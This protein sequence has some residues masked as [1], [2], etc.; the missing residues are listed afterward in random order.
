MNAAPAS[1]LRALVFAGA[2]ALA[3]GAS[4]L[5]VEAAPY[6]FASNQIT[7]LTVTFG[8]G[9]APTVSAATTS[10]TDVANFQ[11][12]PGSTFS[13]PNV[14]VG[15]A[16]AISMAT[17]GTG[18]FGSEDNWTPVGPGA[19]NGTRS[20]AAIG[21]G[22]AATGVS[23]RNVAEAYSTTSASGN[24]QAGNTANIQFTIR[25]ENQAVR[26]A[27]TNLIQLIANA[28]LGETA[29]AAIAN[30]LSV[31]GPGVNFNVPPGPPNL[32]ALNRTIGSGS[33][34]P[35]SVPF[36][37]ISPILTLGE[38]YILTLSSQAI[39]S[40]SPA[41]AVPEPA[42][43]ALLGLGLLGLAAMRRSFAA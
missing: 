17:A 7:G 27:G 37:I 14:A 12:F 42:S 41:A 25:G 36:E 10:I 34:G 39:V 16:N 30:S 43:L 19:F 35:T 3:I 6:A 2:A 1:R 11:G 22:T 29:T 13:S 23:V 24:A 38:L 18:N 5:A 8:S 32:Q 21:A 28:G 26:I 20:D 9:P 40:I 33:V 15:S 4:P 31:I